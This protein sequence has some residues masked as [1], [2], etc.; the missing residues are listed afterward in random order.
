MKKLLLTISLLLLSL[1]LYSQITSWK[2]YKSQINTGIGNCGPTCAA[3]AIYWSNNIDVSVQKLRSI[4]GYKT[5][6]GNTTI[7]DLQ[8][9]LNFYVVKNEL[10]TFNRISELK[11]FVNN[12]KLAII[13]I[14]TKFFKDYGFDASHFIILS[15]VLDQKTYRVQ[16]PLLG[17]D[18][19]FDM[20]TLQKAVG[21]NNIAI[22]V[23]TSEGKNY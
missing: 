11:D 4:I 5:P 2:Y 18:R 12:N 20:P 23:S 22:I 9:L 13:L 21:I 6:D 19:E 17:P 3:M 8:F 7:E 1:T 10:Y 16:D 14:Q 15:A